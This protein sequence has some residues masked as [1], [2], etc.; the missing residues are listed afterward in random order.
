MLVVDPDAVLP[1]PVAA[2]PFK[3]IAGWNRKLGELPNAVDLIELAPC[4]WPHG[5]WAYPAASRGVSPVKDVFSAAIPEGS[6][7]TLHYNG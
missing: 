7:H 5:S 4:H 3:T 6:Y 2:Q 1:A